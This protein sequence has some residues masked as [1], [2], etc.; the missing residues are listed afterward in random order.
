MNVNLK[1]TMVRVHWSHSYHR[2]KSIRMSEHSLDH[3]Y[4]RH[5][6]T[7]ATNIRSL[8]STARTVVLINQF[9]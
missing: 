5:V 4:G 1:T 7:L 9:S 6:R 8:R 3:W 2:N